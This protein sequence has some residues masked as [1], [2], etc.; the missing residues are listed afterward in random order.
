MSLIEKVDDG[1]PHKFLLKSTDPHKPNVACVCL[2]ASE[3]DR[4]QW[5]SQIRHLLQTQKD[6]LKAIQY[7]IAYQKEQTKNV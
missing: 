7:P 3:D 4:N 2:G 1:D 6:F 5:V